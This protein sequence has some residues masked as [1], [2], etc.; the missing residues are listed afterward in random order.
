M[1]H[2]FFAV[3]FSAVPLTLYIPPVRSLNLFLETMEDLCRESRIYS[4]RMYPRVR[5]ACSRIFNSVLRT[6]TSSSRR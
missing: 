6:S 3:A 4:R 5:R 1:L 2:M